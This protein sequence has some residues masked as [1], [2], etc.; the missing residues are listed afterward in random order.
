MVVEEVVRAGDGEG[1]SA[2]GD[3]RGKEVVAEVV[4]EV[5]VEEERVANLEGAFVGYLVEDKDVQAL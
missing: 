2:Q 3:V 1:T 4:W 5:E